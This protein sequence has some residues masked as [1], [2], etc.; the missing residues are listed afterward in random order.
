MSGFQFEGK[1][2]VW[3]SQVR[4]VKWKTFENTSQLFAA[5][6]FSIQGDDAG[7]KSP[8]ANDFDEEDGN[9][10]TIDAAK[11]PCKTPF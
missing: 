9:G 4:R 1:T 11:E 10:I 3:I 8:D 6:S 5:N 2:D 7:S